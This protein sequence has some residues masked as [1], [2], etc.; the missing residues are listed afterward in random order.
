[1]GEYYLDATGTCASKQVFSLQCHF[2]RHSASRKVYVTLTYLQ[3]FHQTEN[4]C[5]KLI[6]STELYSSHQTK[7][8]TSAPSA[9]GSTARTKA[10]FPSN[11]TMQLGKQLQQDRKKKTK[12]T[13]D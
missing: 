13:I 10:L 7:K 9:M 3:K 11:T 5:I 8:T 1:M 12:K 4:T 6:Q 2:P